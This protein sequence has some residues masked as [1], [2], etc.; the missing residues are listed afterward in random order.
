MAKPGLGPGNS[1][2]KK[3]KISLSFFG[4]IRRNLLCFFTIFFN[5]LSRSERWDEMLALLFRQNSTGLFFVDE[6]GWIY[7]C[8]CRIWYALYM[9]SKRLLIVLFKEK[10]A[11][12]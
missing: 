11:F 6:Y 8:L 9:I 3:L 10:R 12:N 7:R 2:V 4:F 1:I 5:L